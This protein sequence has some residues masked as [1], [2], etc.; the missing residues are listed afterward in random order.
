MDPIWVVSLEAAADA[1]D[2]A[3]V[4]ELTALEALV[5]ALSDLHATALYAPDRYA[6]QI[7]VR[8]PDSD[9]A[10]DAAA[11]RWQVAVAAAGLEEWPLVRLEVSTPAEFESE[12]YGDRATASIPT[13]TADDAEGLV[14]AYRMTRELL[15]ATT[16]VGITVAL[17]TM[18][19]RLGGRL[20]PAS[21]PHPDALPVDVSLGEGAP[22]FPV[23]DELS[24]ARL[25][26]AEAL[27]VAVEDARRA[28]IGLRPS[29]HVV[30]VGDRPALPGDAREFRAAAVN[31]DRTTAAAIVEGRHGRARAEDLAQTLLVPT[32]LH[33]DRLWQT[34]RLTLDRALQAIG[35]VE[36]VLDEVRWRQR[37]GRSA[38]HRAMILMCAPREWHTFAGRLAALCMEQRGWEA[39]FLGGNG[40]VSRLQRWL[41][42]SKPVAVGVACNMVVHL[43]AAQKL[44]RVAHTAG[45]PVVVGGEAVTA[46]RAVTLGADAWFGG[47]FDDLSAL[48]AGWQD[49]PP[50]LAGVPA[51]PPEWFELEAA[52]PELADRVAEEL[53]RSAGAT[54]V[55]L[56]VGREALRMLTAAVFLGEQELRPAELSWLLSG[57]V[58]EHGV[59]RTV[60]GALPEHLVG[61]RR[62]VEETLVGLG[63]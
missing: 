52:Q 1:S 9:R 61:S 29:A 18:V 30:V 50:A 55:D 38:P 26:L 33:V 12:H 19:H 7:A 53:R 63:C 23:A 35:V 22:V 15:T 16:P 58:A 39:Q 10:L 34:G 25:R 49:S 13:L 60:L 14:A 41:A 8:S 5:E 27:P 2:G 36:A 31:G 56:A 20:R 40:T 54:D 47:D 4:L 45:V 3:A 32:L 51:P 11:G 46:S 21:F 57:E 37:A 28:L 43:P 59:L 6:L 62:L 42:E 17:A 44:V 24:I 48:M